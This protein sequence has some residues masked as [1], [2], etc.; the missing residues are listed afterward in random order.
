MTQ[1]DKK[2]LKNFLETGNIRGEG[3]GIIKRSELNYTPVKNVQTAKD[4]EG[5]GSSGG[6]GTDLEGASE[7]VVD[8]T[9]KSGE[10]EDESERV[11]ERANEWMVRV[12]ER[13]DKLECNLQKAIE[14]NEGKDRKIKFMLEKSR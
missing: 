2:G 5:S 1:A 6:R 12:S 7:E 8:E 3:K 11:S 10:E 4:K 14:R 9:E 13:V